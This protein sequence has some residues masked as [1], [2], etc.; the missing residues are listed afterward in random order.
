M[1]DLLYV[2]IAIGFFALT[3]A[4][5]SFAGRLEAGEEKEGKP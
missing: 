2:G 5:V 4:L 1:S 3:W